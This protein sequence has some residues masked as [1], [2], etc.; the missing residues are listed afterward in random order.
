M[1][2]NAKRQLVKVSE[3]AGDARVQTSKT[4]LHDYK[5]LSGNT[6]KI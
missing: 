3:K 6:A 5:F 2:A 4:S 1:L